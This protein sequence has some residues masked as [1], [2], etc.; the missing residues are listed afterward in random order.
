MAVLTG[1]NVKTLRGIQ[2]S[3]ASGSGRRSVSVGVRGL[4][5]GSTGASGSCAVERALPELLGD[6]DAAAPT[7]D[8][9]DDLD[10]SDVDET[11]R[12]K[13]RLNEWQGHAKYI[14]GMRMAQLA[15]FWIT[16][17]LPQWTFSSFI[18]WANKLGSDVAPVLGNT[19]H[20]HHFL[21]EFAASLAQAVRHGSCAGIHSTLPATGLPSD[22]TRVIDIVTIGGVGLLVIAY[23]H[24]DHQGKVVCGA[25]CTA[26]LWKGL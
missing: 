18:C 5:F 14:S 1:V 2:A 6:A 3:M 22:L 13:L 4:A 12:I 26:L 16:S 20:S 7:P 9:D 25:C 8:D 17:G 21:R 11:P 15:T 10:L 19:N 24:T 23:I